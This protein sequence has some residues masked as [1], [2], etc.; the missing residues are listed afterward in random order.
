M[1]MIEVYKSVADEA[2]SPGNALITFDIPV[3]TGGA[4]L[5]GSISFS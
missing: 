2:K 4:L 3:R 5:T 1:G